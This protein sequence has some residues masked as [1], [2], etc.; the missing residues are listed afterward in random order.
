MSIILFDD[1]LIT[2]RGKVTKLEIS[3]LLDRLCDFPLPRLRDL[4]DWVGGKDSGSGPLKRRIERFYMRFC[5][6]Q[7]ELSRLDLK[8]ARLGA[9]L[10]VNGYKTLEDYAF[11]SIDFSR[12]RKIAETEFGKFFPEGLTDFDESFFKRNFFLGRKEIQSVIEESYQKA[13]GE[14]RLLREN[15]LILSVMRTLETSL[16]AAPLFTP[17]EIAAELQSLPGPVREKLPKPFYPVLVS[18]LDNA[19][20]THNDGITTKLFIA[21]GGLSGT[22]RPGDKPWTQVLIPAEML[23]Q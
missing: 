8:K 5:R 15:S 2:Q 4:A 18:A 9:T 7:E 11:S 22:F 14:Y 23:R 6:L 3:L 17:E 12:Y 1:I 10:G 20:V 19:L 16:E 13:E 21:G